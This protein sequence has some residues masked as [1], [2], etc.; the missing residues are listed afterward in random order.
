MSKRQQQKETEIK[1]PIRYKITIYMAVLICIT[2]GISTYTTVRTEK[3]ILTNKIIYENKRLVRNIAFRIRK[4]LLVSN[5][6]SI[7]EILANSPIGEHDEML[8]LKIVKPD[9]KVFMANE[10]SFI[11]ETVNPTLLIEQESIITGHFFSQQKEYGI[12]I[13]HPALIDNENWYI[14]AGFP[15][16]QIKTTIKYLILQ[17]LMS[18]SF[19]I[20]L[21]A[22]VSFFLAKRICDPI[23]NL[24]K[25]AKVLADGNLTHHVTAN[26]KDEMGALAR[27]FNDMAIK[28]EKSR[29][30]LEEK[31]NELATEKK[32]LS[33]TLDGMSEGLIAVNADKRIV[34]FNTIAENLSGW[35]FKEVEGKSVDEV[36]Q[37]INEQ[38]NEPVESTIDKA[39]QSQKT[40][41]GTQHD[42]FIS[43]N[44][45]KYPVFV[46]ASPIDKSE[47]AIIR[48]IVVFRDVSHE[49]ELDRMKTDFT[50]SVSHELRTPLTSIK[51]YT[52]TILRDR[53]M[54]E[55]VQLE[56]LAIIDEE[57]NRLATLIEDL[58]EMSR[59]DSGTVK[60]KRELVDISAV[61]QRVST[62]LEPLA[63]KKNIQLKTN[64]ENELP[65]L[66]A[67][68]SKIESVI[69]N[70]ANN[71]IKFTP[72]QGEVAIDIKTAN[73]EMIISVRDTG[74]GI[75]K[76]ALSKIFDK[77][78]RVYRP[79]KQIQ[80]TGLGLSI[81]NKIVSMHDGRIEIESEVGQGTT[82]TVFL[83]LKEKGWDGVERR[84]VST[85][86]ATPNK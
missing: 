47:N 86:C 73:D 10:S 31:I 23:I 71:A 40:E 67:D 82:F 85:V 22:F 72:E 1:M 81:V 8:Y 76:E 46:S 45:D 4:A 9:G 61:I 3:K 44:G 43:K 33:V 27:T 55:E 60:V 53:N 15:S 12:L 66:N 50:S 83:P 36:L 57:S 58:L 41:R 54:P 6:A 49:R 64:T 63:Q 32:L 29:V 35:K 2:V 28:L 39:L 65:E 11:G 20:I 59:I 30:H 25:A 79:G 74:M 24:T 84:K 42:I 19:V 80:G 14:I 75:P 7:E 56:F 5:W 48:I 77:F 21:G 51:A 17:N 37:I 38:T 34:L 62:V 52:E 70:L 69:I 26:T 78:Y 18:G 13:A 16:I 68:A